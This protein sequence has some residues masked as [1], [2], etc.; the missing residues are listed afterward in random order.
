MTSRF[1]TAPPAPDGT[2]SAE[3]APPRKSA[4]ATTRGRKADTRAADTGAPDTVAPDT[5]APDTVAP[6]THE[7]AARDAGGHEDAAA[8]LDAVYVETTRLCERLHRRYLDIVRVALSRAGDDAITPVQAL[9]LL[10]LGDGE[11]ELR[12]L[13]DRG[14]YLSTTA[15]YNIRKLA[16][17]G[18]LEQTRSQRD[19]RMSRLRLTRRGQALRD[20]LED[21]DAERGRAFLSRP[22]MAEKLETT[23]EVLRE[24]ERSF[25]DQMS[26]RRL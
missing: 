22:E 5:V 2:G 7:E 16:E 8:A 12:D 17:S 23:L 14:Y 19:R 18:Y 15:T 4:P 9:M 25:F 6:D 3:D 20:R 26:Y 21:L 13:L 24:L 11:V 10:D 1:D